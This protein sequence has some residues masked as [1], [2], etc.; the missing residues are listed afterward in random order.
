M[1]FFTSETA[2]EMVQFMDTV[3]QLSR[4]LETSGCKKASAIS[5][6]MNNLKD[7]TLVAP[8]R[9]TRAYLSG[10]GP[11][12]VEATNQTNLGVVN[13]PIFNNIDYQTT[14]DDYLSN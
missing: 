1:Y 2:K 10:S 14:M 13:T 3:E 12:A 6:V 7:P 5:K 9:P 8:V 4:Y 11:D